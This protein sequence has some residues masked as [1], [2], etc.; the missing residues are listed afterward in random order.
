MN[1]LSPP[2]FSRCMSSTSHFMKVID[3]LRY[4]VVVIA[5]GGL[6]VALFG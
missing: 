6:I 3:V 2:A 1:F 4:V 5:V